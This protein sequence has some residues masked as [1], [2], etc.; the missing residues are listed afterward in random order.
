MRIFYLLIL[1][2]YLAASTL[3]LATSSNPARLN[4]I[5]AT[6]TA[7]SEIAGFIFN[8]LVKFDKD[9]K[10]IIGDLA[11]SYRFEDN[12][13]VVFKLRRGVKWQDGAPFSSEDVVFTYNIINDPS[14]VSP[15]TS[16]FRMVESVT[17]PDAYTVK[18]RYKQPYF[19]ALETWMMGILPAHLLKDE[20]NLM[21]SAFNLNPVGTGPYRLSKLEFS[22]QIELTAFDDYFEHRPKIDRIAFHVIPDPTT[23]FL[24]LKAGQIDL[25]GLEAMQYERQLNAAFF[26]QFRPIEEISHSYTYLGFNLRLKKFKD[27][28]VRRALSLAIDRQAMVDIL[29]MGH[30][31]VCTGP[32]LPGGPAYNPEVPIPQP[33]LEAAKALL[34]AAGYDDAHPLTFEIATSN[35]TP[36]RPY[37]AEIIQHQLSKIGVKVTLRIMEWQAFLNM[38]VFPREFETVLLGWALSLTPDPYLLW[39]SDNDKPGAFNFIGYHNREVDSLIERMQQ[40]VERD[41]LSTIWQGMFKLITD[42]DPYLFLYIPDEI[43]VVDR[44]IHPIEPALEGIWHNYI[45]W[46]MAPE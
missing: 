10:E 39:H 28:R 21:S 6:D 11:E 29:F 9:G 4:P 16:T 18:V 15:Y 46:E 35:A 1:P 30:G 22:K 45:D 41:R 5:I 27:P 19:K 17:A 40:T 20:K 26:K 8:G 2:L 12:R 36:V 44:R 25:S 24:M 14:V 23:R 37:A 34:K 42:D 31:R 3:H 7:S 13:T 38:V 43:I 33:D 32:F